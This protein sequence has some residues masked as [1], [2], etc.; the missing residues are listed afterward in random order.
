MIT[1]SSVSPELK[2]PT[3]IENLGQTEHLGNFASLTPDK[4]SITTSPQPIQTS[5][6]TRPILNSLLNNSSTT[7]QTK[8]ENSYDN[9]ETSS[10]GWSNISELLANLPTPKS[11]NNLS[12]SSLHKQKTSSSDRSSLASSTSSSSPSSTSEQSTIQRSL[13][14]TYIENASDDQDLYITPTGLQKGNPN[15]ITNTQSHQIQRKLSTETLPETKVSMNP[16]QEQESEDEKNFSQ[17]LETLAQE[18]YILLK[19][20]LEIDKERQGSRYQGRLP[21]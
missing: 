18:I 17:N 21:W 15:K 4:P 13:D 6:S 9:N 16:P 14:S 20:R 1:D 12:T 10:M 5:S 8:Q 3:V 19:Q 11:S 7:I 2:L